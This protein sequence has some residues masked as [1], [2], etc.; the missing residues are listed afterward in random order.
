MGETIVVIGGAGSIGSAI[1]EYYA[2]ADHNV[3]IGDIDETKGREVARHANISYAHVDVTDDGSRE[4]FFDQLSGI[5]HYVSLPGGSLPEEKVPFE[6]LDTAIALESIN[7]NYTG[8]VFAAKKAI[9][10]LKQSQGDR[11]MAFISSIGAVASMGVHAYSS[12][13]GGLQTLSTSL[14]GELGPYGIRTN[15]LILGTVDTA[16]LRRI[17]TADTMEEFKRLTALGRFVKREEVA[18]AVYTMTH[19]LTA[20]TGAELTLDAGQ[21]VNMHGRLPSQYDRPR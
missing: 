15:A 4:R 16:R 21:T 2:N 7:R 17:H 3:V 1:A 12:A 8:Q 6:E 19:M 18:K 20:M 14:S 5:H 10:L 11:S 9:P 13:K